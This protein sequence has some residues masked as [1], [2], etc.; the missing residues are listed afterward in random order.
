MKWDEVVIC[1]SSQ[2]FLRGFEMFSGS[3]ALNLDSKGRMAFPVRYRDI[4][5]ACCEGQLVCTVDLFSKCVLIYPQTQWLS[6]A[7]KLSQ[8]SDMH[9]EQRAMKRL[10][11]GHAQ[12]CSMD[13][14]GRVLLPGTLKEYASLNKQVVLV[15]QLN[16]FE[17]WDKASWQDQMH[18][19]Q[20][21]I[22][23]TDLSHFSQLENF[24]L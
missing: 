9:V 22:K 3:S 2:T 11:L 21:L 16:K 19:D 24:S 12:E 7:Q 17:L 23:S 18:A 1:G 15:G 4:L 10:L 6:I 5:I 8:L 14:L 20:E 13:K